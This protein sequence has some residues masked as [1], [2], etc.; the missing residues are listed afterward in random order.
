MLTATNG[1]VPVV[2]VVPSTEPQPVGP[3]NHAMTPPATRRARLP[4]SKPIPPQRNQTE[5]RRM[6]AAHGVVC[7]KQL[8][9][10]VPQ[11]SSACPAGHKLVACPLLPAHLD[12]ENSSVRVIF[13]PHVTTL[14]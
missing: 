4:P 2:D 11:L 3:H 12:A 8:G 5:D 6:A 9:A 1:A 10:I 7:G 14:F 13:S